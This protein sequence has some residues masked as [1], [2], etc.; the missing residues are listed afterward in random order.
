MNDRTEAILT[1]RLL[2]LPWPE[3]HAVYLRLMEGA[4]PGQVAIRLDVSESEAEV[5]LWR[6][7]RRL[8][9]FGAL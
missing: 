8:V 2:A 6:G 3:R 5:L 7:L 9:E 1:E 4:P